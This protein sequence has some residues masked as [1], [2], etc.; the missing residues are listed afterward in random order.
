MGVSF[1]FTHFQVCLLDNRHSS[2]RPK[3]L[4]RLDSFGQY[5]HLF[6]YVKYSL[7]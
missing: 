4:I 3:V 1:D 7:G 6:L 5:I 2:T